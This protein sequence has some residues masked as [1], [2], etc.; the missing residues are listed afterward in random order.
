MI[1]RDDAKKIVFM[2]EGDFRYLKMRH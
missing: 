2:F 1:L